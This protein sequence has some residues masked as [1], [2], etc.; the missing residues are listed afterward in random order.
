METQKNI[1]EITFENQINIPNDAIE[2]W[3]VSEARDNSIQAYIVDDGL[4]SG[5][6]HLYIQSNN[7]IIYANENMSSLFSLYEYY[8]YDN[9]SSLVKINNLNLL[10]TSKVTNMNSMFLACVSLTTLDLSNFNTSNVTTMSSMFYNCSSLTSLDLSSFNTNLVTNMVGMFYQ[11]AKLTSLNLSNAV[12]NQVEYYA[13]MLTE[14]NANITIYVKDID[15]ETFINARLEDT[16][17]TTGTV[18]IVP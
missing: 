9:I 8:I 12:F 14:T 13:D 16:N 15:A 4:G 1:S 17:I 11:C 3:D 6:Y 2:I 7:D 10:D 5:T 18:T